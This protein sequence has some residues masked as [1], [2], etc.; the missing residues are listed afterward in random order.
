MA[1]AVSFIVAQ[2]CPAPV[3]GLKQPV[4]SPNVSDSSRLSAGSANDA[5]LAAKPPAE[6]G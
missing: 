6:P 5:G 2:L 4:S 3:A 1:P